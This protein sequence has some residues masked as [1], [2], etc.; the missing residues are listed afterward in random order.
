MKKPALYNRAYAQAHI[1]PWRSQG[2]EAPLNLLVV[3]PLR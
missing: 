2:H 3:Y 1:Q